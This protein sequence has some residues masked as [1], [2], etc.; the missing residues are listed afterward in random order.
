MRTLC[1]ALHDM[2]ELHYRKLIVFTARKL[3]QFLMIT[4]CIR[5]IIGEEMTA[6]IDSSTHP[7]SASLTVYLSYPKGFDSS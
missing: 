6:S 7:N 1:I 5:S 3:Q 2:T 4:F